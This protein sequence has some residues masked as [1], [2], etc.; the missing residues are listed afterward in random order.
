MTP[1]KTKTTNAK[2]T[3]DSFM[4]FN[5]ADY[6]DGIQGLATLQP[7]CT[8]KQAY[9]GIKEEFLKTCKWTATEKDFEDE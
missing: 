5:N 6:R 2:R 4:Q 8:K 9:W 7:L 3:F 1:T